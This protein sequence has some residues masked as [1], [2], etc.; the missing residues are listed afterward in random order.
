MNFVTFAAMTTPVKIENVAGM[1]NGYKINEVMHTGRR[2]NL[3]P[4]NYFYV[5]A[6]NHV[7]SYRGTTAKILKHTKDFKYSMREVV[8]GGFAKQHHVCASSLHQAA[9]KHFR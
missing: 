8:E 2:V 7:V 6:L 3:R 4:M 1:M 9:S 5:P